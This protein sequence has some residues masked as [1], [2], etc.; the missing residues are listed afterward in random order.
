MLTKIVSL[1]LS[2]ALA[3]VSVVAVIGMSGQAG[4]AFD[5]EK[6]LHNFGKGN[7]GAIPESSLIS[8]AAGN[9][10]G[11]TL[12]G[13]KTLCGYNYGCGTVFRLTPSG[14]GWTE[15]V[16]HNFNYVD[17][18][19]P[20]AELILD[21]HGNL[22]G[23]AEG[24]DCDNG[25]VFELLP[26]KNDEW[27]YKV[28]YRFTGGNDGGEPAAGLIFDVAGNLYGTTASGGYLDSG[29]VFELMPTNGKWS[30]KV[31]HSFTYTT[32]GA[33]P[34]STLIFDAVGNLYG[35]AM[36]SGP[37][38]GCGDYGCGTVFEL[39]PRANGSWNE[40]TL[41]SFEGNGNDGWSPS[42]GM[43]IDT[44]GRLCGTTASGGLHND[45]T[46]FELMPGKKGIWTEKVLHSFNGKDG[47][48]I[49]GRVVS[50]ADGTLYGTAAL[51]GNTGDGCNTY[52]CGTVFALT[53]GAFGRCTARVLHRFDNTSKDGNFP[54]AGL[55]L[56][57]AGNLYGTTV[58]GGAATMGRN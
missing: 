57:A 36:A 18:C 30:E 14:N 40:K 43:I 28:L 52:G 13:G 24:D 42:S 12:Y 26:G 48:A 53:P 20:R 56:D 34:T 47:E 10:Y 45:G 46:V 39:I 9:L 32:D 7:D 19:E 17:G 11:T 33:L 44:S 15:K 1:T 8:D 3:V 25:T 37:G 41:H 38:S 55:V 6:V 23:T 22:Y 51:G 4:W 54:A 27:S 16:L 50:D 35:T 29:T 49:Y 2:A 58:G 5:K 21:A 31:L